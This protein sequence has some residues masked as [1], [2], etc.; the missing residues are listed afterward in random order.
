MATFFSIFVNVLI[1]IYL[2]N[3]GL[4]GHID[5]SVQIS[6]IKLFRY[7]FG[8]VFI[9]DVISHVLYFD[10]TSA[11]RSKLL[12]FGA[13]IFTRNV[14]FFLLVEIIV[15]AS[16][17]DLYWSGV[18][19]LAYIVC[20]FAALVTYRKYRIRTLA[21][22]HIK[23]RK[24]L[25]VKLRYLLAAL[26]L[27][28]YILI[29]LPLYSH[30]NSSWR[31]FIITLVHPILAQGYFMYARLCDM[32]A[33]TSSPHV[34]KMSTKHVT[35]FSILAT[36]RRIMLVQLTA[37]PQSAIRAIVISLVEDLFLR[38]FLVDMDEFI[39][40]KLNVD[41]DKSE[42]FVDIQRAVWMTHENM[43]SVSEL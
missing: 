12:A 6:G 30:S 39:L 35:M 16:G 36:G 17:I 32:L 7:L 20:S 19:V 11:Q 25:S 28:V 26:M 15:A 41:D 33:A 4:F 22:G 21:R 24:K 18:G 27:I 10:A 29:I 42:A 34:L 37:A 1:A 31:L 13:R 2:R 23:P 3:V 38:C 40:R 14:I 9:L 43:A 5:G 8:P